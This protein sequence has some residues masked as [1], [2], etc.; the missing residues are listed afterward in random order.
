MLTSKTDIVKFDEDSPFGNPEGRLFKALPVRE[1][2]ISIF[3]FAAV[4]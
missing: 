1:K 2:D 4:G 3:S